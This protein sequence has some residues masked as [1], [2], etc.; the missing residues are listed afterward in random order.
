MSESQNTPQGETVAPG[1]TEPVTATPQATVPEP[2]KE[3]VT[4]PQEDVEA[5]RK[6][7]EQAELERNQ[8]RN[9]QDK[10]EKERED[11]RQAELSEVERLKEQLAQVER[12]KNLQEAKSFRDKV[13]EEYP[14]ES[15]R[16]I[17][18][19]L[20][21]ANASNLTWGEVDNYED[22][23]ADLIRQLDA[24]KGTVTPQTPTEPKP[25]GQVHPNNPIP[26]ND[27]GQSQN[28]LMDEAVRTGD[29]TKVLHNVPSIKAMA[30]TFDE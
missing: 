3:T 29:W 16:N 28:D 18:K 20:I 30:S 14:D 2:P 12:D 23:K 25:Q 1:T 22:A 5:L 10:I 15:T 13:V 11:A 9:K 4:P 21:D 6:R 17:A 19:A 24:L 27:T 26:Q 7:A 8:L